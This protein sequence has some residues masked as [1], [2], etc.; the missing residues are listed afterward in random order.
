MKKSNLCGSSHKG[1][2]LVELAIVLVIIG[3]LVG[4]GI[5]LVGPLTKR[6]KLQESKD[7]VNS[8][9][10]AFMGYAVKN[11]FLPAQGTYNPITPVNAFQEVG[12][13]GLDAWGKP[14]LY[15]V[16]NEVSGYSK[17][18]AA[19]STSLTITDRG[20]AKSN[21]AFMVV[22]GGP[23]YNIQTNTS[24]YEQDIPNIDDFATDMN[25]PEEYDDIAQYVALHE[26]KIQLNCPQPLTITTSP[27]LP[28]GEEDSFYSYQLEATGGKPPYT[29]IGSTG[30]GLNVNSSGLISGTINVNTISTTGELTDCSAIINVSA[31]VNDS[32][33]SSPQSYTG[34][35]TVRPKPLKIITESLPM[36]TEGNS[37]NVTLQGS[38]GKNSYSW[39]ITSGS[40]PPGL[41]LSSGGSIS[42]TITSQP[43]CN[44][45]NYNFV[46]QLNDGCGA[47]TSRPF[48]I[49]VN[50]PDCWTTTTTG[51]STT[52]TS[53]TTSTTTTTTTLPLCP[54]FTGWASNLPTAKNCKPYSGSMTVYGGVS[55]YNWSLQLGN[56]PNGIN[57][58]TGN[59]S[60]TCNLTGNPS[61]PPGTYSFT[62]GVKDSCP[63]PGPQTTSQQFSISVSDNCPQGINVINA[64]TG[65]SSTVYYRKDGG[66]C[67]QLPFK[68]SVVVP[69]N[70]TIEFY[71]SNGQC[72]SGQP[73]SCQHTYCGLKSKDTNG[74][75]SIKL[76]GITNKNCSFAD[77]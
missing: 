29:W 14:M 69:Q 74:N 6:A 41:S 7:L 36:G 9:K 40:L 19:N 42:G 45:A 10:Q 31:T 54:A 13:S 5:G 2:T 26:L 8:A 11:G 55:P 71:A 65:G 56:L 35:I 17:I 43:G 63:Y 57:F 23:N 38:G 28:E 21:I 50:D 37:Y 64:G 44:P 66:S 61:A 62:V 53:S 15:L 16:A 70:S 47:P 59:T 76:I 48:S 39:Q 24:I 25:R 33:N 58:C 72:N 30:S 51:A 27:T 46:A 32:A 34:T 49:P 18:C 1:F 52:T 75:C 60:N 67:T 77:Q 4:M 68:S 12:T 73:P 22:S 20:N 3:I